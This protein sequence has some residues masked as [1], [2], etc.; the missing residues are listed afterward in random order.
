MSVISVFIFVL[1]LFRFR[2]SFILHHLSYFQLSF[3]QSNCVRRISG[4]S[5]PVPIFF[6]AS[7][8]GRS[9]IGIKKPSKANEIF[10]EEF[11]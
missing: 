8:R 6:T 5:I 9:I 1:T 10:V 7:D 11:L 4:Y 3:E 2:S